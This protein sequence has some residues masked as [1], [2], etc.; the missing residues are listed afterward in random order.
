MHQVQLDLNTYKRQT[1]D[2]CIRKGWDKSSIFLVWLLF[3][4]EIGELASAIRHH[5]KNFRK[6]N[7]KKG[8]GIDVVME[9]GDVFNYLF[10]IAGILD[11]DLEDM[12]KKQMQKAN[13]KTYSNSNNNNNKISVSIK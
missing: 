4:E 6:S 2:L 3:M 13:R 12:W 5:T 10:Q 1:T 9:M 7:I 11:I 8:N